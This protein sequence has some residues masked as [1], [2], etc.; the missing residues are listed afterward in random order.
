[1]LVH[2]A[3]EFA[4]VSPPANFVHEAFIETKDEIPMGSIGWECNVHLQ[5]SITDDSI[6]QVYADEI[7]VSRVSGADE[8]FENGSAGPAM[9]IQLWRTDRLGNVWDVHASI[10]LAS[11]VH[12]PVFHAEKLDEVLPEPNELY[13][14]LIFSLD[15]GFALCKANTKRLIDPDN[16]GQVEPCEWIWCWRIHAREPVDGPILGEQAFH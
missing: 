8:L 16:V 1:M 13:G 3:C 7:V 10:T 15:V 9:A 11:K 6:V 4:F 2:V 5:I 14:Q 12:L